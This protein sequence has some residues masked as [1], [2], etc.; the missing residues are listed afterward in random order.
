MNT[1]GVHYYTERNRRNGMVLLQYSHHGMIK[2]SII[3]E[4][5]HF[6]FELQWFFIN[7]MHPQTRWLFLYY[8]HMIV[9]SACVHR[10]LWKLSLQNVWQC[11][12]WSFCLSFVD[13]GGC[14][15]LDKSWKRK[16]L[17]FATSE[18]KRWRIIFVQSSNPQSKRLTSSQ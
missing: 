8:S 15:D 2:E 5:V 1:Y 18:A 9:D 13:I 11:C 3:L 14:S 17:H 16:G 4:S 6:N 10:F 12:L 7:D